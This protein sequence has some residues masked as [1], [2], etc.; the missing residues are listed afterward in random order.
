MHRVR[1]SSLGAYLPAGPSSSAFT[2][3]L[4]MQA[5]VLA[6]DPPWCVYVCAFVNMSSV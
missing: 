4:M 1:F 2:R 6:H 3:S 5:G